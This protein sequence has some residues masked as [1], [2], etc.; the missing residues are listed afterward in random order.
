MFRQPRDL[1]LRVGALPRSSRRAMN[2]RHAAPSAATSVGRAPG[3][4][5]SGARQAVTRH[6]SSGTNA[7]ISRSRS[8]TRR[9]A[10]DCTRPALRPRA[11]FFQSS[12]ETWYP[13]MR[14]RMRRACWAFTL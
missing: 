7:A 1:R 14:S 2:W 5:A 11:T 4:A 13:T 6:C 3:F 10:T 9:T 12:G 8:T